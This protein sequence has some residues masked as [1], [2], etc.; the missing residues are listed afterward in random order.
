MNLAWWEWLA[1]ALITAAVSFLGIALGITVRD[2]SHQ[3][4]AIERPACVCPLPEVVVHRP[5]QKPVPIYQGK[6]Q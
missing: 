3:A 1:V 2:V 4:R 6:P 5:S